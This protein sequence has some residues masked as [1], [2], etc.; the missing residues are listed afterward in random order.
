MVFPE[1]DNADNQSNGRANNE[2][3]SCKESEW[4]ASAKAWDARPAR[5]D[6]RP[7]RH[8]QQEADFAELLRLHD[9]LHLLMLPD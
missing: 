9:V 7:R 6:E 1:A 8:G 2:K 3:D 5:Q 4:G